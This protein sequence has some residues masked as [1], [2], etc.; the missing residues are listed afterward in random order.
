ME[1][2]VFN[3]N[4]Q[5]ES[6]AC[7]AET[8]LRNATTACGDAI[9]IYA[10]TEQFFGNGFAARIPGLYVH[11]LGTATVNEIGKDLYRIEVVAKTQ[12]DVFTLYRLVR[13]GF[14]RPAADEM[15]D[16]NQPENEKERRRPQY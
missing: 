2:K 15:Y 6:I 3:S 14:I 7:I 8:P 5:S 12:H 9:D 1:F 11:Q 16:W 4:G 13:G 10:I